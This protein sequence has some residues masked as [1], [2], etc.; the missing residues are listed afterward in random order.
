MVLAMFDVNRFYM[1]AVT[2]W[3]SNEN[4]LIVEYVL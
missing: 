1:A 3:A 4:G 2:K